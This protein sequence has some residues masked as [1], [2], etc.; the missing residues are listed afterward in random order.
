MLTEASRGGHLTVA[1]LLL[2]QPRLLQGHHSSTRGKPSG[3]KS[4]V[5]NPH[6]QVTSQPAG[7][8][9]QSGNTKNQRKTQA[10]S[11]DKLGVGARSGG[12]AGRGETGGSTKRKNCLENTVDLCLNLR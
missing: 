12:G 8:K 11:A 1:N 4:H 9:S 2:K 5:R 7:S 3:R 10:I 6:H